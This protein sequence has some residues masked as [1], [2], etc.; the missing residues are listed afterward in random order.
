VKPAMTRD[1]DSAQDLLAKI[2]AKLA[3]LDPAELV[4]IGAR[5]KDMGALCEHIATGWENSKREITQNGIKQIIRPLATTRATQPGK[6]VFVGADYAAVY[7]QRQDTR[8]DWTRL[9]EELPDI[10]AKYTVS[11][12]SE[13]FSFTTA[14]KVR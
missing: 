13:V 7:S 3:T 12:P 14:D 2:A 5:C 4:D 6:L 8:P 11:K 1:F 9:R 10:A